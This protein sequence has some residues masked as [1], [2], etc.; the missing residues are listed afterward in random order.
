MILIT[1]NHERFFYNFI[2]I[3]YRPILKYLFAWGLCKGLSDLM[4]H[5]FLRGDIGNAASVAKELIYDCALLYFVI[6]I[7]MENIFCFLKRERR[8][9]IRVPYDS[10]VT[11][12]TL[13]NEIKIIAQTINISS[14][15]LLIV[16]DKQMKKRFKKGVFVRL[17]QEIYKIIRGHSSGLQYQVGLVKV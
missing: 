7:E 3:E 13:G 4:G 15:G 17:D 11:M 8:L 1:A 5:F 12:T 14:E 16:T 10:N 6:R 9:H 2:M